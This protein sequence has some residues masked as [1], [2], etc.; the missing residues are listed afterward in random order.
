MKVKG[1]E[2]GTDS[3]ARGR[4]QQLRKSIAIGKDSVATGGN[5]TKESIERKIKENEK[6]IKEITRFRRKTKRKYK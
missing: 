3:R 1:L 6:R 2:L 4:V 5:E